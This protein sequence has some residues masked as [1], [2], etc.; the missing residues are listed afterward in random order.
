M[1]PNQRGVPDLNFNHVMLSPQFEGK[2]KTK[3]RVNQRKK[4][5]ERSQGSKFA[6]KAGRFLCLSWAV[7]NAVRPFAWCETHYCAP[8]VPDSGLGWEILSLAI[9]HMKTVSSSREVFGYYQYCCCHGPWG[10]EAK[11]SGRKGQGVTGGDR[12]LVWWSHNN[13]KCPSP[14]GRPRP[15]PP[16][17]ATE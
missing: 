1:S 8:F 16:E 5:E 10:Y 14:L 4:K 12:S 13:R 7:F 11:G 6:L 15:D 9:H 3:S 2:T 17:R